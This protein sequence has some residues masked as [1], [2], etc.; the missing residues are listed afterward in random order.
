MIYGFEYWRI[1]I[2]MIRYYIIC[3]P[4]CDTLCL[5]QNVASSFFRCFHGKTDV[6]TY[7]LCYFRLRVART[8][9]LFWLKQDP[10]M[11]SDKTLTDSW[12]SAIQPTGAGVE[13]STAS[14][15]MRTCSIFSQSCFIQPECL[16]CWWWWWSKLPVYSIALQMLHWVQAKSKSAYVPRHFKPSLSLH[17]YSSRRSR[18]LLP[19]AITCT[20]VVY[21]RTHTTAFFNDPMQ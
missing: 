18:R 8:T 5:V 7:F 20:Q 2:H 4:S 15:V 11:A 14:F 19:V 21:G 9:L 10:S 16:F 1:Q 6:H 13:P 12:V 17:N 3:I